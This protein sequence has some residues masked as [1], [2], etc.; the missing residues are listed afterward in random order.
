MIRDFFDPGEKYP[1]K[2]ISSTIQANINLCMFRTEF[3]L[4]KAIE[5]CRQKCRLEI[6]FKWYRVFCATEN[7]FCGVLG[8][9]QTPYFT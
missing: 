7:L 6:S 9:G 1:E 5:R 8:P 4:K 2:V 3:V